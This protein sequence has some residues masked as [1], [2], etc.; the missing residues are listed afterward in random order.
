[1][2]SLEQ[3]GGLGPRK[4]SAFQLVFMTYA[5][6]C[7]GAYGL[8]EMVSASGPGLTMVVLLV[9]PLV[10]AAPISLTCAEL[11]SRFPIEGGYYYGGFEKMNGQR[12]RG[13]EPLPRLSVGAASPCR[14]AR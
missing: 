7:S 1:L 11:A 10:Y 6:I 2:A 12:R 14:S 13:G 4:A 5:V 3:A 8:E 9:L